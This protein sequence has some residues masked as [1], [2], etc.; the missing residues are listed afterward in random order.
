MR[1]LV[2]AGTSV[3]LEMVERLQAG[4]W[5]V[6]SVVAPHH[7]QSLVP[8]GE[9]HIGGFGGPAGLV[10][11]LIAQGVEVIVDA[12]G[13]FAGK[14]SVSVSEAARATGT[15]L[16]A[17]VPQPWIPQRADN[18]IEVSDL[19]TAAAVVRE[20]YRKVGMQIS[21][22]VAAKLKLGPSVSTVFPR[23][24]SAVSQ[25]MIEQRSLDAVV[26][27]NTGDATDELSL[28]AAR[29]AGVPVVMIT[30]EP[31][32]VRPGVRVVADASEALLLP[33]FR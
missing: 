28:A 7:A 15:P 32:T 20:R 25:E 9:V 21:P 31:P 30:P 17:I 5:H 33:P 16:I 3:A 10:K 27:G 19:R 2:I 23:G 11:W 8:P 18:W 24:G 22:E 13:P 4:G 26:V 1:A 14:I 29:R 6:T 12:A